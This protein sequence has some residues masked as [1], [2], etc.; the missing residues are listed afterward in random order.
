MYSQGILLLSLLI[1]PLQTMLIHSETGRYYTCKYEL[2]TGHETRDEAQLACE[3]KHGKLAV[4]ESEEDNAQVVAL[5]AAGETSVAWIGFE[6]RRKQQGA[7]FQEYS[8]FLKDT[9][10]HVY[11]LTCIRFNSVTRLYLK[12]INPRLCISFSFINH[13]S[14][15]KT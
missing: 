9:H 13:Y 1:S 5:L 2:E 3:R 7:V 8:R 10:Y 4:I 12:D 15:I 11:C 6:D 14:A